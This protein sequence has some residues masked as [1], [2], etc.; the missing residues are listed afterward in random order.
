[1]VDE[2]FDFF[3]TC[4]NE[5]PSYFNSFFTSEGKEVCHYKPLKKVLEPF[6][7]YLGL[8][9]QIIIIMIV[10]R[11]SLNIS[12]EVFNSAFIWLKK[13]QEIIK[14]KRLKMNQTENSSQNA[15]ENESSN[16]KPHTDSLKSKASVYSLKNNSS[17]MAEDIINE[18]DT[19]LDKLNDVPTTSKSSIA[20]PSKL[21]SSF[22]M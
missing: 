6:I 19:Y 17:E 14:K 20:R 1:M 12:V 18:L 16:L 11:F 2:F 7:G 9:L 22:L 4:E 3:K 15:P 10:I 21:T 13:Q 8:L 5:P